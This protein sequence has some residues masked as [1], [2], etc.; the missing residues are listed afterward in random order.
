VKLT[1]KKYMQLAKLQFAGDFS[2]FALR[3]SLMK[4]T[5]S[6]NFIKLFRHNLG[7]PTIYALG[8]PNLSKN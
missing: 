5:P 2:T 3:Q 4:L 7:A 8:E 6:V 1:Q